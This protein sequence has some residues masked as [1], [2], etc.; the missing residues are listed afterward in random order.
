[1]SGEERTRWWVVFCV[2]IVCTTFAAIQAFPEMKTGNFSSFGV[3]I[4]FLFSVG[5]IVSIFLM[6]RAL[7]RHPSSAPVPSV[8]TAL[9]PTVT[10]D[11]EK[12]GVT[13]CDYDRTVLTINLGSRFSM[14]WAIDETTVLLKEI[15]DESFLRD[16]VPET[17][18]HVSLQ[19]ALII[20]R[21]V[22]VRVVGHKEFVL[23]PPSADRFD[24]DSGLFYISS[25]H[26]QFLFN[27]LLLEHVNPHSG[28]AD[29]EIVRVR[30]YKRT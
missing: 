26:G 16:G 29:F 2:Q 24:N 11:L 7:G 13:K 18:V 15:K 17:C 25:S 9:S 27:R 6:V 10:Q 1:M 28:T 30:V 20:H 12:G 21:G 4:F 3:V 8:A 14:P 5:V 19:A 23:F 22:N